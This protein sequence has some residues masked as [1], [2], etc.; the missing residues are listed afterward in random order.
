VE[1]GE[2]RLPAVGN[3]AAFQ[4][5]SGEAGFILSLHREQCQLRS[6]G[7]AVHEETLE[8]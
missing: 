6:I 8:S 3:A 1:A 5:A 4:A 7:D 2:F